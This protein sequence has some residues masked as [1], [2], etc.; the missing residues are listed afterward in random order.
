MRFLAARRRL[1]HAI[2]GANDVKVMVA[3]GTRP[4]AIKM[5]PVV[6][7]L[8]ANGGFSVVVA[9]TAQH[10]EMLDQA[11]RVFEIVPDCDLDLMQ[12]RQSLPDLTSRVILGVT[13]AI[14]A[15]EPDAL[16]VHGDTTTTMA[17]ALAGFYSKVPVCHV[18]AGLRSGNIDAPWPEEMNR[19]LCAT[20]CRLHFAP[21]PAAR[22]NLLRE[23]VVEST[24]YVTGNT[25]VDALLLVDRKLKTDQILKT[26]MKAMFPF[27]D[28]RKRM[29][30]VTAHRRENFGTR[31]EAILS[32]LE[33]LSTRTDLQIVYPVHPNPYISGPAERVLS[34]SKNIHL[35]P[36]QDYVPFVYLM[37]RSHLILTDSGGIQEEA[38][39]LGKPV[40][41]M[42]DST[43]RPEA[44]AAGTARLV[45]AELHRIVDEVEALL[46]QPDLYSAMSEARSPYG[47][48]AAAASIVAT[49]A[50]R[51][52]GRHSG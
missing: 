48:G 33:R 7:A 18:E 40:L 17:S 28:F 2:F 25:V 44:V 51:L 31:F 3:F 11:L 10:R 13:R 21:T 32:A 45:G 12:P 1:A 6:R 29:L 39:S 27:L 46:D 22:A 4:E 47:D 49:L 52:A 15:H 41:V 26:S 14:D 8:K 30:L 16:L 50:A 20:L 37:Q 43:E 19:R 42:R 9:V 23:G 5:A 24:V 36:P 35:I 34:K 38:P